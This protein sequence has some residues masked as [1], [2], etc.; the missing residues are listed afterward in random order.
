[1]P[2]ARALA[3]VPWRAEM[4]ARP[5]SSVRQHSSLFSC[6]ECAVLVPRREARY[7]WLAILGLFCSVI[8]GHTVGLALGL[9][10]LWLEHPASIPRFAG[11]LELVEILTE[12]GIS[13]SVF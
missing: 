4:T 13:L 1:M 10:S 3:L 7:D 9:G 12:L 8:L 2:P 6:T 11:P 5:G